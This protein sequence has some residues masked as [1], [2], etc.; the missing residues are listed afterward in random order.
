MTRTA[1]IALLSHWRRHRL[2]LAML[3]IGLALA[4]ALWSGV[5]AINSEARKS[6]DRAAATLGQDTLDRLSAPDGVTLSEFV[7][8]RRAGYL[9]SPVIE[10]NSRIDAARL[11]ILGVDPLTAPPQAGL[12]ALAGDGDVLADFLG[13]EGLLLVA[14]ETAAELDGTDLPPR[15]IAADLSPGIAITDITTA[16][17]LLDRERLSYL[18]VWQQQPAGLPPLESATDLA[19]TTPEDGTDLAELTDSFHLNLT[20]FGFLAFGV[21]L[22]IVQSAIGLAVE[23][24][25][26]TFRT[27]RALGL[28]LR[29]LVALLA[30]ELAAFAL[31]AGTVGLGLGYAIAA[32]LLPGVAGT[33]RGLYGAPVSGMLSF[34][35][36]WALAGLGLTL[37]GTAVAGGQALWTVARMPLLAPAQPRAWAM[38]S[39]RTLRLQ[40][41]AALVLLTLAV[42]LVVAGG[43]LLAAFGSL[44]AL[45]IGSALALPPLLI[46]AL[47]LARP[48]ARGPV[49]E[50]LLADARQQVPALSLALMALLLA[51]SAN[52]GVGTMVG[53]FRTTFTGWL[54]HRLAAELYVTAP[55]EETAAQVREIAATDAR[56]ILPSASVDLTVAGQPATLIG[57]AADAATFREGWPLLQAEPDVWDRLA[58]GDGVLINEQ[59]Y[60]REDLELGAPLT[61]A[62]GWRLPVAGI[63][64]DYGNPQAQLMIGNAVL[65]DRYPDLP[66][67]RFALRIAPDAAPALAER[68]RQETGLPQQAV[69]NQAEVKAISLR[70]FDQT[71]LVTG[72]L[73]VLTLGVAGV[74]VL[75]ALLTLSGLRLPQ[76]APLW[77]LGIR[78]ARLARLEVART[79][80]L[81]VLTWALAVPVGL[82]LAW[83]LLAR[84]NVAAFGWRL[85]MLYFPAEWLWLAAAALTAAGLACVWPA[86]RLT[87]LPPDRL[88]RIFANER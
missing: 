63:Y 32:A 26:Q 42:I 82:A 19:R 30:T 50:W 81:A 67:L 39:A 8:L 33:L 20:A 29:R 7:E 4:T 17:R 23:Q 11:R 2:Q 66:Q 86:W 88:L 24:R 34:D 87:R 60:R 40:G 22:F 77:A 5:Q 68:L 55:D 10:G 71:F 25:R 15:R 79:L 53:S 35:P 69:V 85:P 54:D 61:L 6:Y 76:L 70:V 41:A 62:E 83:V 74:A 38:A 31:L 16:Q 3:L 56:E 46:G 28:P 36:L 9:V 47:R 51:L 58:A 73:N 57:I 18:S 80:I 44:A 75:T 52:V 45:L 12:A 14:P 49:G 64:A 27:L 48:L 65:S 13:S 1:I 84:V 78:P 59:L 72:A 21:G 37:A 43:S